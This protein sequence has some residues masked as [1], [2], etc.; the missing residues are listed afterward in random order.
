MTAAQI[1]IEVVGWAGALLILAAYALVSARRVAPDSVLYQGLNI[2]G[3]AG[4]V[5]NGIAHGAMP[6][7]ILNVVWIGIGLF[8]L[9]RRGKTA[10]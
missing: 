1:A 2:F 7:A 4:F 10:A 8:A 3:A 6:S 5:V 9:S